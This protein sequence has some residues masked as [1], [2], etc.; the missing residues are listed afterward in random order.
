MSDDDD[1]ARFADA[2]VN[3]L[4]GL[5]LNTIVVLHHRERPWQLAQF[6]Q[7]EDHLRAEVS[8]EQI[9]TQG[10]NRETGRGRQLLESLRWQ[11]ADPGDTNWWREIRWPATTAEYAELVQAVI[12]VLR[13]LNGVRSPAELVYRAWE[14]SGRPWPVKLPGVEPAEA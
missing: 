14:P 7:R 9:D 6:V 12:T 1:W 5:T 4:A 11:P 13:E 3:T 10:T 8:G 2:L